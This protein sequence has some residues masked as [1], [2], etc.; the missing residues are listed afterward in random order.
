MSIY[1]SNKRLQAIN[2][3]FNRSV[4]ILEISQQAFRTES[5]LYSTLLNLLSDYYQAVGK[6]VRLTLFPEEVRKLKTSK[7]SV[8]AFGV[9]SLKANTLVASQFFSGRRE[10]NIFSKIMK[11]CVNIIAVSR[12][13]I[14]IFF[15][16]YIYSLEQILQL[17]LVQFSFTLR[18]VSQI[19]VAICEER[20][21]YFSVLEKKE[22]V[23]AALF[24]QL[25]NRPTHEEVS[26]EH[27]HL[28][29][30]YISCQWQMQNYHLQSRCCI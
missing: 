2:P 24:S 16:E 26:L 3:S 12:F 18:H 6:T 5:V 23:K 22:D 7:T 15:N 17:H 28:D 4:R 8:R 9:G 29:C 21:I 27:V 20:S 14:Y 11:G 10:G 25:H 1:C 30:Y 13:F 19:P